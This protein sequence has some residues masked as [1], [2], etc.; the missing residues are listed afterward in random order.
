MVHCHVG[1]DF[2]DRFTGKFNPWQTNLHSVLSFFKIRP[3]APFSYSPSP[4]SPLRQDH[5]DSIPFGLTIVND[6]NNRQQ[7]RSKKPHFVL[8]GY[9]NPYFD[10]LDTIITVKGLGSVFGGLRNN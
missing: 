2:H 6:Q 7:G 10:I 8:I 9:P 3:G 4:T 5:K 1:I